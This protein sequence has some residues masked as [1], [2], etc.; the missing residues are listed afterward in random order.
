VRWLTAKR[1][2]VVLL[3][4]VLVVGGGNLWATHAQI[5][6]NN[7]AAARQQAEQRLQ[8]ERVLRLIC[9]TMGRLAALRPP[10]GSAAANPSRAYEQELHLTLDQLGP[11][12]GCPEDS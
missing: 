11:D 12:L 10:P 3:F 2:Q 8:G 7:A 4:L 9:T 6:S 5:R 1:A